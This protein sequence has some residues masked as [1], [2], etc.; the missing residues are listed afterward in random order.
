MLYLS[1]KGPILFYFL[2]FLTIGVPHLFLSL[3]HV[4][5]VI[6]DGLR[7]VF[8]SPQLNLKRLQLL[9]LGNLEEG[10]KKT[11]GYLFHWKMIHE[12]LNIKLCCYK[13]CPAGVTLGCENCLDPLCVWP[14]T[15]DY[16]ETDWTFILNRPAW[17]VYDANEH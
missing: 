15:P 14:V 3:L 17:L 16:R 11:R 8:Q 12:K 5:E 1:R 2:V 6:D 10:K 13:L 9:H 4:S 7:Q